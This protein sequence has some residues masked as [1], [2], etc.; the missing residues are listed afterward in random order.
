MLQ[1][2]EEEVCY[3]PVNSVSVKDNVNVVKIDVD[4]IRLISGIHL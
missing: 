2:N 4:D 1:F 3:V